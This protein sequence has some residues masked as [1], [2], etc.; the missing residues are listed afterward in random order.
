MPIVLLTFFVLRWNAQTARF[1]LNNNFSQISLNKIF[2]LEISPSAKDLLVARRKLEILITLFL[3][4][5]LLFKYSLSF[6]EADR[7]SFVC[8]ELGD[9]FSSQ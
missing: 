9:A 6:F 7:V 3:F 4:L 1:E 2:S 5:G 8:S